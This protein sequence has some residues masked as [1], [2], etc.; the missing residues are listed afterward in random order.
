MFLFFLSARFAQTQAAS[1]Y[2]HRTSFCQ[3]VSCSH[4]QLKLSRSLS[5]SPSLSSQKMGYIQLHTQASCTLK[6]T[7]TV[8]R[9]LFSLLFRSTRPPSPSLRSTSSPY[10]AGSFAKQILSTRFPS[11]LSFSFSS[12]RFPVLLPSPLILQPVSI[13]HSHYFTHLAHSEKPPPLSLREI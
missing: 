12:H 5:R 13:L 9:T 1:L 7:S 11:L 4:S 6:S 2:Q 10:L 3:L 8:F